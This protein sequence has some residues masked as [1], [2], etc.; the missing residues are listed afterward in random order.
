MEGD[1]FVLPI[2]DY[3]NHLMLF[4]SIFVFF[5]ELELTYR[6]SAVKELNYLILRA[7]H[8]LN[9]FV[10]LHKVWFWYFVQLFK[11]LILILCCSRNHDIGNQVYALECIIW[12]FCAAQKLI[13]YKI[14]L[15]KN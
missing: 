1:C 2:N 8:D 15:L 13:E 7:N 14:V 12:V 11:I 6:F 3:S 10:L 5:I 4:R 9:I